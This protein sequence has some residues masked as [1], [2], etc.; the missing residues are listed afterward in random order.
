MK[1]D[2]AEVFDRDLERQ[3]RADRARALTREEL[4]KRRPSIVAEHGERLVFLVGAGAP[5]LENPARARHLFS[6]PLFSAA[7]ALGA[8]VGAATFAL[9]SGHTRVVELDEIIGPSTLN[10]KLDGATGAAWA[11]LVVDSIAPH[12]LGSLATLRPVIVAAHDLARPIIDEIDRRR[13]TV[14][15]WQPP[16]DLL[17]GLR[18]HQR[19]AFLRACLRKVA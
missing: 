10:L 8:R 7:I 18:S 14:T 3:E 11:R 15:W 4:T 13:V 19:L 17:S 9:S 6:S 12:A 2:L 1:R 16:V 5:R